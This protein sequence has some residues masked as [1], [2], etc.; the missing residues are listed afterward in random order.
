MILDSK[1]TLEDK[2]LQDLLDLQET[3]DP[4]DQLVPKDSR[5]QQAWLVNLVQLDFQVGLTIAAHKTDRRK[6][7]C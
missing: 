5:V 7:V 2:D 6:V 1:E 3:E 4:R